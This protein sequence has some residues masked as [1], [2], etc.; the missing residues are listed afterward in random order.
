[1]RPRI[2]LITAD[3]NDRPKLLEHCVWQMKRQTLKADEHFIIN[4]P[5]KKRVVDIVPRIK[6]GLKLA[7]YSKCDICLIIENDDYY[8]DNYVEVM[9]GILSKHDLAGVDSTIYYSAQY[10]MY[11]TFEHKGRASLFLTGFRTDS[12]RDFK[13]PADDMLY[14]DIYLWESHRGKKGFIQLPIPAIGMKHGT[15]FSPGNFHNGISN[16]R[17]VRNMIP[18]KKRVWLKAHVRPES[19]IFYQRNLPCL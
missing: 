12:M 3:R 16:G 10:N 4:Y 8:P 11:K 13:W 1:M 15:G 18:D 14:F 5:G 2:A 9:A 6:H 7:E 17:P 19:F